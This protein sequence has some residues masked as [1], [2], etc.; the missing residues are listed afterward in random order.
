LKCRIVAI[1]YGAAHVLFP[2]NSGSRATVM[3]I[4]LASSFVSIFSCHA[5]GLAV[6]RA[7]ARLP[8]VVP[9]DIADGN[10][11]GAPWS[12]EA[13]WRFCDGGLSAESRMIGAVQYCTDPTGPRL[14]VRA[15]QQEAVDGLLGIGSEAQD[16]TAAGAY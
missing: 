8:F 7:D 15:R 13:A 3:A 5:F 1:D 12:G 4:R 14:I 11:V 9:D 10:L 16:V 6:A 2:D